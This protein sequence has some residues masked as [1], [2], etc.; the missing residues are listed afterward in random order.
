MKRPSPT[1]ATSH[2]SSQRRERREE[3]RVVQRRVNPG[4][5]LAIARLRGA[6]TLT[7]PVERSGTNTMASLLAAQGIEAIVLIGD[8]Y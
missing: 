5:L 7:K 4:R 1:C 3:C 2:H 8:G 6:L